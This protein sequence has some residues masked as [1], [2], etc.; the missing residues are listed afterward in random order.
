MLPPVNWLHVIVAA[1]AAFAISMIFYSLPILREPRRKQAMKNTSP[2][3]SE[4]GSENLFSAILARLVNTFLYAFMLA[5]FLQLT[6]ISTLGMGLLF[7]VVAM[8]RAALA[9]G[10]WNPAMV[11]APRAARLVD[12]ARFILM[13]VV[14]TGILLFWR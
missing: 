8:G 9:P 3:G 6:G 2:R 5:W 12:N 14:M 1:A 4:T 11:D 7:L 10:G 13:Y